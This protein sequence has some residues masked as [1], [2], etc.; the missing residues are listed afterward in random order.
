MHK[1][2]ARVARKA[3]LPAQF[4]RGIS[5][6][7]LKGEIRKLRPFDVL[8]TTQ[9]QETPYQ[10]KDQETLNYYETRQIRSLVRRNRVDKSQYST[11]TKALYAKKISIKEVYDLYLQL[12][13]P[14]PLHLQFAELEKLL[15]LVMSPALRDNYTINRL[16][17]ISDDMRV[18][19]MPLSI[20]E[21]NTLVYLV[22]RDKGWKTQ[23]NPG[24]P[25]AP[26]SRDMDNMMQLL[27]GHV[28][29]PVST[30]NIVLEVCKYNE[31]AFEGV[32][33]KM[34]EKEVAWDSS[35]RQIVFR[36]KVKAAESA[37]ECL[38]VFY[39]MY[40]EQEV[41]TQDVNI[42][43]WGLLRNKGHKEADELLAHL[44]QYNTS[45]MSNYARRTRAS[46]KKAKMSAK[47]NAK[48]FEVSTISQISDIP[49]VTLTDNSFSMMITNHK[50][51]SDCWHILR[52]AHAYFGELPS[53]CVK[54]MYHGFEVNGWTQDDLYLLTEFVLETTEEDKSLFSREV[55]ITALKAYTKTNL[56]EKRGMLAGKIE[57]NCLE[58]C[59]LARSAEELQAYIYIYFRQ[60]HELNT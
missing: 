29:W 20:K 53:R 32:L 27:S 46:H 43:F 40:S 59:R 7:E 38:E 25:P 28:D 31:E 10:P 41:L 3:W 23:Y 55:F 48:K 9:Y 58:A 33:E 54:D 11:L 24:H 12:P 16:L 30:F 45:D 15:D 37:E 56:L 5:S 19:K 51:F 47:K 52:V 17:T 36:Q 1:S 4:F 26:T 34:R 50:S 57:A 22:L 18:A 44:A 13:S 6:H 35:T 42:L 14:R 2:G 21:I 60:L 49:P 8:P 39:E